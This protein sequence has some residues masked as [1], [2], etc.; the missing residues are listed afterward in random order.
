LISAGQAAKPIRTSHSPSLSR[1]KTLQSIIAGK[2]NSID[3]PAKAPAGLSAS[4]AFPSQ[5][6][7][8]LIHQ[9]Y[10]IA[11]GKDSPSKKKTFNFNLENVAPDQEVTHKHDKMKQLIFEIGSRNKRSSRPETSSSRNHALNQSY[12]GP[13]SEKDI[14]LYRSYAG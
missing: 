6:T 1:K 13:L 9:S 10:D 11:S 5:R 8:L 7:N 14:N 3:S 4:K 2:E 12:S